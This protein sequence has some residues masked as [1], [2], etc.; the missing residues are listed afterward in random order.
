MLLAPEM[1][2][3]RLCISKRMHIEDESMESMW[4]V[5]GLIETFRSHVDVRILVLFN[6]IIAFV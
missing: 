3:Q 1:E 6:C 2:L 4:N 5:L